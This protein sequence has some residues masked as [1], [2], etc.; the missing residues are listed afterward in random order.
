MLESEMPVLSPLVHLNVKSPR[1]LAT[2]T[3]EYRGV[4]QQFGGWNAP[5]LAP[6]FASKAGKDAM[7][8]Q[9]ARELALWGIETSI[10]VPGYSPAAPITS[11]QTSEGIFN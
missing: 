1:G 3:H 6:Y 4:R 9:Y 11:R 2:V 8:V 5:Y 10:I 7:A